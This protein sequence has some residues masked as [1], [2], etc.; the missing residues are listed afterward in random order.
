MREEFLF[1]A[2][3]GRSPRVGTRGAFGTSG[4]T[5]SQKSQSQL[6]AELYG[7]ESARSDFGDEQ[8]AGQWFLRAL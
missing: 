3:S 6:A 5:G 2:I 7:R 8:R 1:W 4:T